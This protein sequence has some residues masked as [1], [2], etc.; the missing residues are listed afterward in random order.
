MSG[1]QLGA[2]ANVH[3]IKECLVLHCP[4]PNYILDL[5]P[6]LRSILAPE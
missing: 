3:N 1:C 5:T 4:A 2:G 6:E